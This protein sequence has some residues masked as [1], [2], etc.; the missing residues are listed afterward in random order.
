MA[1]KIILITGG[2]RSG[3]SAFAEKYAARHGSK[4]AY[5]ATA[6]IYDEE[7]RD[8]VALHQERR[9]THWDTYEAP[10]EAERVI[11][12]AA[13][14]HDMILFDCL[15]LYTSNMLCA[16]NMPCI[17]AERYPYIKKQI[18]ALITQVRQSQCQIIF[19]TNEVGMG[20]VPDNTLAREYRDLAGLANQCIAEAADAVYLVI[21]GIAVD[22]KKLAENGEELYG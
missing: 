10:Y 11:E 17:A 7:M 8:R 16:G 14:D 13:K 18:Q 4:I 19:V 3:K 15:T 21:S 1:N 22:V 12:T 9:P 20:I 6:Q 2:A 5:I